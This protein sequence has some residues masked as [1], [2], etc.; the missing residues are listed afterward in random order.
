[1][2][3]VIWGTGNRGTNIYKYL[4]GNVVAFIESD[5]KKTGKL[6][7][8]IPVISFDEFVE[9]FQENILIVSPYQDEEIIEMLNLHHISCFF[10]SNDCPKEFTDIYCEKIF[11]NIIDRFQHQSEKYIVGVTVLS[12]VLARRIKK[13]GYQVV[14]LDN[15]GLDMRLLQKIELSEGV[16]IE[17]FVPEHI[18][19]N[20]DVVVASGLDERI[21]VQK[22]M[23]DEW[24]DAFWLRKLMPS[25]FQNKDI[26]KFKDIHKG[27]RCFIIAT[28]PS[29]RID[30]LNLLHKRKE[31]CISM[32][33]IFYS[34]DQTEWR[35]DYYVAE[36]TNIIT[37]YYEYLKEVSGVKFLSDCCEYKKKDGEKCYTF[38]LS[39][40][41]ERF[42]YC[43]CNDFS[44]G[45]SCGFSVIFGCIYLAMFMG[46]SKIYIL[47]ADMKYVGKPSDA[48][49]HFYGEKDSVSAKDSSVC[50]PFHAKAVEKNYEYIAMFAK[51][52]NVHIYNATRGGKLKNFERADLDYL[53]EREKKH[54]CKCYCADI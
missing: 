36:D 42:R 14:L 19:D 52:K 10:K 25:H 39:V 54:A 9:T 24:I 2:G 13:K 18:D 49:N 26:L 47:G 38:H 37:H 33:K 34:F 5:R 23:D 46:F 40:A 17:E 21:L 45:Y 12:I 11:D 8:N 41:D 16:R 50:M 15:E 4:K 35:P 7:F 27:E 3:Y 43:G 22:T 20:L 32:N 29:I 31:K 53:L 6:Y 1:M 28:G 44:W 30:D 51:K 48:I